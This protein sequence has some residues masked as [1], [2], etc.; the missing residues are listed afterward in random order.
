ML[1][2]ELLRAPAP[3]I[4]I[5]TTSRSRAPEIRGELRRIEVEGLSREEAIVLAVALGSS[6]SAAPL[7]AA[8]TKGHPRAPPGS[9]R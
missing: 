5:V 7:L 4:L 2:E 6:P 9:R 1:L 8:E 3:P